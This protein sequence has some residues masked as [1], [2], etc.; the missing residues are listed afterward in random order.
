MCGIFEIFSFRLKME[1]SMPSFSTGML[2]IKKVGYYYLNRVKVKATDWILIVDESIGIG[3]EKLLVILG[4]R[5]SQIDFTRP[6]KIDDMEPIIVKSKKGWTGVEISKELEISKQLLGNVMYATTDA[7]STIKKGLKLSKIN[8]VYDVTHA[9]A[10]M[11]EKIYK[12]DADFKEFTSLMG[13]MRL[14]LCCSKH[15]HIIPPNQRSKSRFLNI[16]IL[17]KWSMKVLIALEKNNLSEQEKELLQWVNDKK[18]F[19]EEMSQIITTV[20]ELSKILKYNGLS[21]KT[22]KL[23]NKNLKVCNKTPKQKHFKKMFTDYL[24]TNAVQVSRKNKILLCSSD[25]IE[26]T[27]GKN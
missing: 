21:N 6:L 27:F 10:I 18:F 25:I 26:T 5:A 9:I 12:E 17:T 7:G 23:C 2:W 19:I 15:A 8:H 20:E 3:Q 13:Q 4:I 11:L 16:D 14:K 24:N 1:R 22:K